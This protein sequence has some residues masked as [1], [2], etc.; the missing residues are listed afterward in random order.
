MDLSLKS[1][2]SDFSF[3]N[4]KSPV[5]Y[6]YQPKAGVLPGQIGQRAEALGKWSPGLANLL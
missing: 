3:E 4:S 2:P 6:S 5:D 1:L